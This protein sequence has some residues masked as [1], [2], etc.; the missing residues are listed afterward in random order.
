VAS[1][2]D[3]L[4]KPAD[5]YEPRGRLDPEGFARHV[6]FQTFAPPPDLRPF[7]EHGWAITWQDLD[8][9]YASGEVMHR[10]YVDV[11]V[12]QDGCGIQGTFRGLRTYVATVGSGRVVGLRFEPGAFHAVWDGPIAEMQ[13]RVLDLTDVFPTAVAEFVDGVRALGDGEAIDALFDLVRTTRPAVDPTID[14]LNEIIAAIEAD[15]G[16]R[17]VAKVAVAFGRSERWVQQ[18]FREYTGVGAKWLLQRRTL[19]A[20]A[21][22]IRGVEEPDWAG[23]A[24]ELGYSSQQHF[25]THF[26]QVLGKTPVQYWRDV[27]E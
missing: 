7:V 5:G 15:D 23:L 10:P 16:P 18:L 20:A 22:R 24:Y 27:R 17:T 13:D 4:H 14:L 11:F 8:D 26:R 2:D 12:S 25:I 3:V 6:R 9:S 1:V 21:A 19:L